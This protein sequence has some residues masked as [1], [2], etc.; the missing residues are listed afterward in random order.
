MAEALLAILREKI[1]DP[2][3]WAQ[4]VQGIYDNKDTIKEYIPD[5]L[6]QSEHKD[7]NNAK[8]QK[9][10]HKPVQVNEVSSSSNMSQMDTQM[11]APEGASASNGGS[12]SGI[13]YRGAFHGPTSLHKG[14]AEHFHEIH[15]L[16]S[17]KVKN[18]VHTWGFCTNDANSL[19]PLTWTTGLN[20]KIPGLAQYPST[21]YFQN[22]INAGPGF[23]EYL[24]PGG[25]TAVDI[26]S[27]VY[28]QSL[29]WS[30]PDILDNKL[31][32]GLVNAPGI[33]INYNK[34]RLKK[35]SVEISP[36]TFWQGLPQLAP[37]CITKFGAA[38]N[39]STGWSPGLQGI[40]SARHG[41][42]IDMDYWV[43]RDVYNDFT[44]DATPLDV[45]ITPP[46]ALNANT[47]D[48]YSRTVRSVR[49]YDTYLSVMNNKTPF[50][51]EREVNTRGNY[52]FSYNDIVALATAGTNIQYITNAL[53]SITGNTNGPNPLPESF[54]LVYGP[55]QCPF[56]MSNEILMKGQ[57][58]DPDYTNST[59]WAN[60]TTELYVQ[61]RA[62]WEAFDFNYARFQGPTKIPRA[63]D[64]AAYIET[65]VQEYENM[66][67]R[68][69]ENRNSL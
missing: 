12:T 48:L 3:I 50:R 67:R 17:R 25:P 33:M 45:P 22:V 18:Y 54:N 29:N 69:K 51:F 2:Q 10:D 40:S 52:F 53:E 56:Y 13:G 5:S 43:L 15:P 20:P 41:H 7:E 59:V 11:H 58:T 9:T 49:N 26:P 63:I 30:V 1:S 21:Q 44:T 8:R 42:E 57:S 65:A 31:L 32:S 6:G 24:R 28:T 38:V 66:V 36:R 60:I 4:V 34:F 46:E 68:Q 61:I 23:E 37:Q 27:M 62:E 55:M 35:F 64:S 47:P 19:S 14:F 39:P 16:A